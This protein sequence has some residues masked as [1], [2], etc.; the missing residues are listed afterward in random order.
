MIL[1][2]SQCDVIGLTFRIILLERF[3]Y[4]DDEGNLH[5]NV[6]LKTH[7]LEVTHGCDI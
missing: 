4:V 3:D 1:L 5:Q 6:D 7:N 2:L